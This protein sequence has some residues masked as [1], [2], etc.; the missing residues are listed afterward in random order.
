MQSGPLFHSPVVSRCRKMGSHGAQA[1]SCHEVALGG[2]LE[3]E[4]KGSL[5][6]KDPQ[7]IPRFHPFTSF[8]NVP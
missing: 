7:C 2:F 8:K 6:T 1:A 5:F 3:A 4:K